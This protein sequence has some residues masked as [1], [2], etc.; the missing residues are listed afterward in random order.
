M[1]AETKDQQL[2]KRCMKALENFQSVIGLGISLVQSYERFINIVLY[3]ASNREVQTLSYAK[4]AGTEAVEKVGDMRQAQSDIEKSKVLAAAQDLM[5][6]IGE[7]ADSKT[8]S[9]F[10][11]YGY[12][13]EKIGS[14]T[15]KAAQ[16]Q[17]FT[18]PTICTFM[19]S[20]VSGEYEEEEKHATSFADYSCGS[21]RTVLAGIYEHRKQ[22]RKRA[23][24]HLVDIDLMSCKMAALNCMLYNIPALVECRDGLMPYDM[25]ASSVI[26]E[27]GVSIRTSGDDTKREIYPFIA[28]YNN[29]YGGQE[30]EVVKHFQRVCAYTGGFNCHRGVMLLLH[31]NESR[32]YY[33]QTGNDYQRYIHELHYKQEILKIAQMELSEISVLNQ[34]HRNKAAEEQKKA[35][36]KAIESKPVGIF[37]SETVQP[38]EN[39]PVQIVK[40][41]KPQ[42]KSQQEQPKEQVKKTKKTPPPLISPNQTSLF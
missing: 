8:D 33:L 14:S 20:I 11:A 21:G 17:F 23:L 37:A 5:R 31:F 7:I 4:Q 9:F 42:P 22:G 30:S 36:E 26:Y 34:M 38:T 19:A 1:A 3:L 13:Y 40:K 27:V 25:E 2:E 18:P 12:L 10:D 6:S 35:M 24:A 15:S 41:E 28:Q 32:S 39:Q 29:H 16:G